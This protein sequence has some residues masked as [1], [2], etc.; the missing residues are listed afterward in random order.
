MYDLLIIGAGPAGLAAA[1]Q[2]RQR[3]KR[4]LL[5]GSDPQASPLARAERV[6]NYPGLRG[7]DGAAML[8]RLYEEAMAAGAE[9]RPGRVSAVQP[10]D[11]V[12][13]ASVGAE[14]AEGAALVLATGA[15]VRAGA[16]P[17]AEALLGRGVSRC[18]TCDGMFYRG[19]HAVVT[20]DAPELEEE[21]A[22]LRGMGVEVTLLQPE[23]LAILGEE[24][25]EAVLADG[26]RVDCEAVFLLQASLPPDALVPGLRLTAD[27]RFIEVDRRQ[28]TNLPGIFAAGDC[29]GAPLQIAKAVGEGQVAAHWA[30]H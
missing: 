20:G 26:E 16:V 5:L 25:V 4:C 11:G 28:A 1:I 6:D 22:V 30:T 7:M 27:G 13:Y 19:K 10:L 9:R 18:A 8:A 24:R 15:P 2:A 14:V 3:G 21:A 29:T 17:G 12:I 23:K